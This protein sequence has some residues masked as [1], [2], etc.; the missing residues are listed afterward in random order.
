VS[1]KFEGD[2]GYL[3]LPTKGHTGEKK[4]KRRKPT[5]VGVKETKDKEKR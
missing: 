1:E 5:R 2:D 4:Q 3:R